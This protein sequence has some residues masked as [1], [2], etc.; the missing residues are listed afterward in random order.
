M[1]LRG[2]W[3]PLLSTLK[4]I[5][6]CRAMIIAT[7]AQGQGLYPEGLEPRRKFMYR[8]ARV[9]KRE[10]G[11]I[12]GPAKGSTSRCAPGLRWAAS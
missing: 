5:R 1:W 2:S 12:E 7:R 8:K 6:A 9:P 11:G 4:A 10:T 3:R